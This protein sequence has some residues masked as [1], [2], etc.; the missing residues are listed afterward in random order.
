MPYKPEWISI[1]LRLIIF[2]KFVAQPVVGSEKINRRY[3]VFVL[4][5]VYAD[6]S[7]FGIV[8]YGPRQD[9][10]SNWQIFRNGSLQAF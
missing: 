1:P 5:R 8:G 3:M 6:S 10:K 7:T 2:C 9:D 4:L